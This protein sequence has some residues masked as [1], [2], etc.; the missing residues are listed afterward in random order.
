MYG[1]RLRAVFV[2]SPFSLTPVPASP[3]ILPLTE[4]EPSNWFGRAQR[5]ALPLGFFPIETQ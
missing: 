2:R 1:T 4:V 3:T 5:R